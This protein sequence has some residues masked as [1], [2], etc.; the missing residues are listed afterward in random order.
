[1][2]VVLAA[3]EVV[4]AD[5]EERR[6]ARRRSRCARRCRRTRWLAR[7]TMA[8]AFQRMRLLMRRSISRSPGYGGC[9]SAGMVL[10]YGVLAVNGRATPWREPV[11]DQPRRAD[12]GRAADPRCCSTAS[13]DS[14]QALVSAGSLSARWKASM[15]RVYHSG[16]SAE[17]AGTR[18]QSLEWR[19]ACSPAVSG[20]RSARPRPKRPP[21]LSNGNRRLDRWGRRCRAIS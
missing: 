7:T 17:R 11:L 3:E 19:R 5:L 20:A 2:V 15:R 1:M 12:S 8:M 4:E 6:A 18:R 21:P 9:S 16:P 10:T 14:I 13:N